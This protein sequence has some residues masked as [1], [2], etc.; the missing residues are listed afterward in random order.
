M[1]KRRFGHPFSDPRSGDGVGVRERIQLNGM[2][3][4]VAPSPTVV[5]PTIPTTVRDHPPAPST[6]RRRQPGLRATL[7][8][9][10]AVAVFLGIATVAFADGVLGVDDLVATT[11]TVVLTLALIS[12]AGL[13]KSRVASV[14]A[15]EL[16]RMVPISA[17]TAVLLFLTY[18]GIDA[19]IEAGLA[20]L[21]G[22]ATLVLLVA[23]RSGFDAWLRECRRRGQY[24]RSV[25]VV[26]TGDEALEFARLVHDHPELGYRV[27]GMVGPYTEP[28]ADKYVDWLGPAGDEL[29]ALR[30]TGADGVFVAAESADPRDRSLLIRRLLDAGVHV[31]LSGG[32]WGV[33]HRRLRPLPIG[34][35]PLFYLEQARLRGYRLHIKR[36]L[37]LVLAPLTLLLFSPVLAISALIIKLQDGGSVLYS[38]KRVGRDGQTFDFLKLRT[39]VERADTMQADLE[40][41]NG[42]AGPLFKVDNDPRVTRFGRFLRASSIDELPQLINVIRGEMSLVGPRPALPCEVSTFDDELVERH[43]VPPGITGLWQVEARDNPSFSAYRRLDLFYIENWSLSLDLVIL[44]LTVEHV[45]A[46]L[47]RKVLFR[48]AEDES[49]G[50]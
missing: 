40:S 29:S 21:A 25:I 17:A 2:A 23:G 13:Y 7:V 48:S 11:S 31:H 42:R 45:C 10:D 47:L 37:D 27:I 50:V 32:V 9:I 8:T 44:I 14:R 3:A 20:I 1:G 19:P 33:D 24:C 22:C 15:R 30:A 16:S 39:M 38:Q 41:R 49:V 18:A 28:D 6:R 35:E 36:A 46:R 26:G 4:A 43:R 12:M 5:S 34:Y